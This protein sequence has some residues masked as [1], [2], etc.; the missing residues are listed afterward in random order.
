MAEHVELIAS[1]KV[2]SFVLR[3]TSK[4]EFAAT[5]RMRCVARESLPSARLI[6]HKMSICKAITLHA[7]MTQISVDQIEP[8][9]YLIMVKVLK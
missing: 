6:S 8:F 5:L 3:R 4:L 1:I 7:H 2:S 9:K